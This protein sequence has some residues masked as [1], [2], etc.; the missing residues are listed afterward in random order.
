MQNPESL[1]TPG[2]YQEQNGPRDNKDKQRKKD[3]VKVSPGKIHPPSRS[4][5]RSFSPSSTITHQAFMLF[6]H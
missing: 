2:L 1:S 6:L 3:I 4:S 5:R